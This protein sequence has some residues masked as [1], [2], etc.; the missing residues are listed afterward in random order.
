MGMGIFHTGSDVFEPPILWVLE[1]DPDLRIKRSGRETDH[2]RSS[3][4]KVKNKW[5]RNSTTP[6]TPAVN[7]GQGGWREWN[8][9]NIELKTKE[10]NQDLTL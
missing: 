10:M 9:V 3:S 5:I 7:Y 6:S 2:S 1:G 8:E 4:A